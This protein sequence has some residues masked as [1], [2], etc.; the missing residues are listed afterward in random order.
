MGFLYSQLFVTPAYPT[1]PFTGETVI[2][3]GSNVGLG[4]E[5]ARHVARLGAE[6]LIL[7]VRNVEA[8]EAARRDILE[9]TGRDHSTIEVWDL[10]LASTESVKA[11]AARA[12]SSLDR[13][14]VV[15]ENAGV[16]LAEFR[17]NPASGR[18]MSL[19]VNVVGTFLL[20]LL[21][22][23]K[24][25]ATA[26]RFNTSPRL[27]VVSSETH[28]YPSIFPKDWRAQDNILASLSDPAK[29]K[30]GGMRYPLTKLLE[31]LV[32]RQLAMRVGTDV[33]LDMLNPG[34][35][36]SELARSQQGLMKMMGDL[37]MLF[38]ARTTE[39]GS[40]TLVAAAAAGPESHG[41]YMHDGLVDDGQL[42]TF[43]TSSEGAEAGVR[44]WRELSEMLEGISPG[45]LENLRS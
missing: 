32:V 27:C 4:K 41:R 7:A 36:R 2:V 44:V 43:V 25:R 5:A 18:E 28:A 30:M 1:R 11:F 31:V 15:L 21:L 29:A 16:A 12:E 40:R 38:L 26:S 17:P 33:V 37:L 20:A 39:V 10:D 24:L 22:L 23:P 45:I 8:G 19:D 34:L 9:S 13:L 14:D 6:R 35:C 3:T 42:G